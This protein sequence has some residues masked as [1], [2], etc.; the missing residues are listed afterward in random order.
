MDYTIYKDSDVN[1]T[2]ERIKN[3]L[4][5]VEIEV[6]EVKIELPVKSEFSPSTMAINL[7]GIKEF[8]SNGKGTSDENARASGYAEFMERIQN[9]M[10]TSSQVLPTVEVDKNAGFVICKEEKYLTFLPY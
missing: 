6:E 7:F 4:K 5:S 1:S 8:N 10:L 2:V 3:I 9:M